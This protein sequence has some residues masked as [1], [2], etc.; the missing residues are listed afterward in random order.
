M[1]VK[2]LVSHLNPRGRLEVIE[3]LEQKVKSV[4]GVKRRSEDDRRY[5]RKSGA[6]SSGGGGVVV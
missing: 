4:K 6:E 2:A 1:R 3:E 5:K